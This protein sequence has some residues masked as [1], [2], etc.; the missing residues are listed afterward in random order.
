MQI[1]EP[2]EVGRAEHLSLVPNGNQAPRQHW[3][4]ANCGR[5]STLEL[6]TRWKP[7][8]GR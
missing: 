5:I 6:I 3:Y 7:L 2:A 8:R 4:P 1:K